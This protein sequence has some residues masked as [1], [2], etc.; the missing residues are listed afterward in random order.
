MTKA[1][2][3]KKGK[4][5]AF[6]VVVAMGASFV[7]ASLAKRFKPVKKLEDKVVNGI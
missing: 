7:L 4:Q 5:V 3:I 6:V 2:V 1:D